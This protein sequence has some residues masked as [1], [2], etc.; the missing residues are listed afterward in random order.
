MIS[1]E[2]LDSYRRQIEECTTDANVS[3]CRECVKL[4]ELLGHIQAVEAERD[5]IQLRYDMEYVRE[6]IQATGST[7]PEVVESIAEQVKSVFRERDTLKS[8][9]EAV[10]RELEFYKTNYTNMQAVEEDE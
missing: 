8:E 4:K 9:L 5:E 1:K 3:L 7:P 2:R 10:K 6:S